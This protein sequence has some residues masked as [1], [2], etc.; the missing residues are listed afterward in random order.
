M[1]YLIIGGN[2]LARV[3]MPKFNDYLCV[4]EFN[5]NFDDVRG[6][7]ISIVHGLGNWGKLSQIMHKKTNTTIILS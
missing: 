2:I 4:V 5:I 7:A 1:L 6:R 3:G